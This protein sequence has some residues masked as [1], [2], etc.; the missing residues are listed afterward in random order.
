MHNEVSEMVEQYIE[1][2][3]EEKKNF[4]MLD[5]TFG[6]GG[7]SIKLLQEAKD[8]RD[9][10]KILGCDLDEEVLEQCKLEYQPLLKKRKLALWHGNYANAGHVNVAKEFQLKVATKKRFDIGLLDLGF[11]SY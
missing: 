9:N 11:S 5:C 8:R 2:Y 1:H 10:L 4:Q 7:H 6:G 3:K